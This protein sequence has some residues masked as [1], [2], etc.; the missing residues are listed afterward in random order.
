[1]LPLAS[2]WTSGALS[3]LG[4]ASC[5]LT[6]TGSRG[7]WGLA[8]RDSLRGPRNDVRGRHIFSGSW[9]RREGAYGFWGPGDSAAPPQERQEGFW[10]GK[11]ARRDRSGGGRVGSARRLFP[12]GRAGCDASPGP[13]GP[14]VGPRAAVRGCA[15][16][17]PPLAVPP[18]RGLQAPSR[19]EHAPLPSRRGCPGAPPEPCAWR[20]PPAGRP[21]QSVLPAPG[22]AWALRAARDLAP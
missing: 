2:H 19:S 14:G 11:F 7:S 10:P 16:G 18:R 20:R 15:S 22:F 17:S 13:P 4:P 8:I 9:L 3:S 5:N 12:Q 1:M 21:V 6:P